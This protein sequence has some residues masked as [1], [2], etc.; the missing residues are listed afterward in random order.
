MVARKVV[1][2]IPTHRIDIR[3]AEL[4]GKLLL[5]ASQKG[6]EVLVFQEALLLD[7]LRVDARRSER[8]DLRNYVVTDALD[9]L[10]L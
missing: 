1:E 5:M 3:L 2:I 6:I 8:F 7:D 4:V 9:S 10:Y